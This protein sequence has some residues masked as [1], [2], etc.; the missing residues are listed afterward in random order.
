MN[1]QLNG[2]DTRV[3]VLEEKVSDM[4]K[5]VAV[6]GAEFINLKDDLREIKSGI[7]WVQRLILGSLVSGILYFIISGGI[8]VV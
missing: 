3:R 7:T 6:V 1:E 8:S 4:E 5:G 2:I